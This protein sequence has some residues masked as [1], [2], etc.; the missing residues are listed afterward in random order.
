MVIV[1]VPTGST[2]KLY[3]PFPSV[4]VVF[5]TPVATLAAVTETPATTALPGSVTIPEIAPSMSAHAVATTRSINVTILVA[6]SNLIR[7]VIRA[8][9]KNF[10]ENDFPTKS[11]PGRNDYHCDFEVL[12][13]GLILYR[14]I[15][16]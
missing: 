4:V 2:G 15:S 16:L 3:K 13:L 14:I 10:F 5:C 9:P 12:P 7:R 1:Y 11:I 6:R 8:P